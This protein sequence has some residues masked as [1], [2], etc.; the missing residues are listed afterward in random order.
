MLVCPYSIVQTSKQN[1]DGDR[2]IKLVRRYSPLF[3]CLPSTT[4]KQL[5]RLGECWKLPIAAYGEAAFANDYG[6]F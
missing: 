2:F 3:L 4:V 1:T 5:G 6:A